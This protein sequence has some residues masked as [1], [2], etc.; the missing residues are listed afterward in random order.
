MSLPRGFN[1][2]NDYY[3]RTSSVVETLG[4]SK[5]N[6]AASLERRGKHVCDYFRSNNPSS[7]DKILQWAKNSANDQIDRRSILMKNFLTSGSCL[8]LYRG[9]NHVYGI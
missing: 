5:P 6:F 1:H 8:L 3:F 4:Q 2:I 7:N 9:Y